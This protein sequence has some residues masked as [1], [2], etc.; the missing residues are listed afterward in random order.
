MKK[1][2]C[3][4]LVAGCA[5]AHAAKDPDAVDKAIEKGLEF[6]LAAQKDNGSFTGQYGDTVAI[7]SLAGMSC[8]ATGHVP[9]DS[10]YGKLID[11][12]LDYVIGHHNDAGYFGEVGNGKM[13]AHS[14]ATLFLTEVSGM[15]SKERQ[16]QID[17]LLPKAIKVI[18]DAQNVKKDQRND[19][20]WRYTPDARDSDTS[21][22]G[23]ALM[24]LRSARLNGAQVPKS[25]IER[26]VQYMHRHHHKEKGCFGYQNADQNPVTLSGAGILCLELCGKHEDPDSL[27]AAKYLMSVYRD[28]LPNESFAYYGLYYASQGLFQIGGENW[29]EFSDWMYA[30]YLPR[31]RGSGAWPGHGSEQSEPYATA[32]TILAFAVPYRQLP[33]YQRD[34]TVDE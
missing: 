15:V 5:I 23:W 22:S 7:A 30:A 13:Y 26:A 28:K 14:I 25:A 17:E 9:G 3:I 4:V 31:Q 8:L 27:R 21:C 6:L 32:M 34:E 19:G 10:K 12:A 24:A 11:R 2:I 33:V 20:G 1:L 18:L 29:K 16:A